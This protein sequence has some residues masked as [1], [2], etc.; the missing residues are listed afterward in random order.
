MKRSQK[1]RQLWA[2]NVRARSAACVTRALVF[3]LPGR[4]QREPMGLSWCVAHFLLS[5]VVTEEQRVWTYD[6]DPK[7]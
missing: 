5:D 1:L 3:R 7:T 6:L 2:L 4:L